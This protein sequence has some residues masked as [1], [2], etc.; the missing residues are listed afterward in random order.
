MRVQTN[1]GPNIVISGGK[2]NC[3]LAILQPQRAGAEAKHAPAECNRAGRDDE[4]IDAPP[5]QLGDVLGERREPSM[6]ELAP[7][8]VNEQ[9]R[10]DLQHDAAELG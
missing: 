10:A 4:H 1:G 3:G 7:H 9:R 8:A 2:C 6:I 5:M